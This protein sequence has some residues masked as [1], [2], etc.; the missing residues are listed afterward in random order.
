MVKTTENDEA[1][2]ALDSLG[3]VQNNKESEPTPKSIIP[4]IVAE[5]TP[6]D[7]EIQDHKKGK[8]PYFEFFLKN[9]D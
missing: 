3:F 2:E 7:E 9:I 8:F 4:K 1:Q 6:T 5:I